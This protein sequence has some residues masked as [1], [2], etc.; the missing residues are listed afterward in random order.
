MGRLGGM[1]LLKQ[2][3]KYKRQNT[4][5]KDKDKDKY[6]YKCSSCKRERAAACLLCWSHKALRTSSVQGMQCKILLII[7][8]YYHTWSYITKY[9]ICRLLTKCSSCTARGPLHVY[10]VGARSRGCITQNI[11]G[12]MCGAD[13]NFT[14][15]ILFALCFHQYQSFI[16]WIWESSHCSKQYESK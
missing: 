1:D 16:D 13:I 11:T 3:R 14:F 10:S 5:Y 12:F 2:T 4:K 8:K 7:I 6:K 9:R 15:W